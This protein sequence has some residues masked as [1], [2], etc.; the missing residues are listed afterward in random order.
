MKDSA[1]NGCKRSPCLM[2][3]FWVLALS[4]GLKTDIECLSE[5]FAFTN[6][7]EPVQ[8]PTER[9]HLHPERHENPIFPGSDL[10]LFISKFNFYLLLWFQNMSVINFYQFRRISLLPLYY[11]FVLHSDSET[12]TQFLF[13]STLQFIS[14]VSLR[15]LRC[16]NYADEVA[17]INKQRGI[18]VF[19]QRAVQFIPSLICSSASFKSKSWSK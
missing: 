16:M 5:T 8:N 18:H 12:W 13:N 15:F 7:S 6:E 9:Y 11:D 4:S 14:I 10:L 17:M 19:I 2:M 3:I 1:L